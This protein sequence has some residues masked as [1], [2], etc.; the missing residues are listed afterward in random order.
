[1]RLVDIKDVKQD[2][3]EKT[4]LDEE[5]IQIIID[6]IPTAETGSW[7]EKASDNTNYVLENNDGIYSVYDKDRHCVCE[8][9]RKL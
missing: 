4:Y 2:F 9:I 5:T 1:M 3:M 7:Q 6:E 8:F